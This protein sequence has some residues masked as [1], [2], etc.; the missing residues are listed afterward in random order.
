MVGA[1]DGQRLAVYVEPL[2]PNPTH[3]AGAEGDLIG[4]GEGHTCKQVGM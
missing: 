4:S 2:R 3:Q 1:P